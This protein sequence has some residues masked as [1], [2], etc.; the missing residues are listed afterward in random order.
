ML[1]LA[2][3]QSEPS[4]ERNRSASR[5]LVGEDRRGE[6]LLDARSGSRSPR[7]ASRRSSRRGS[8]RTSPRRRSASPGRA[9]TIVGSTKN[10]GRSSRLPPWTIVAPLLPSPRRAPRIIAVDGP[11][12]D[13]RAHQ[14]PSSQGSPILIAL[15]GADQPV[16]ERVGDRLVDD[17]PPERRAALAGGPDGGEQRRRGG[18]G[19]GRRSGRRSRALLPPSSRSDR[20]SRPPTTSADRRAPSGNCPSP[21]S[22]GSRRSAAIR[23]ARS[24]RRR[25]RG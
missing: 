15:V 13:Q 6:P 25:R 24:R 22:A 11:L 10:P 19:R 4:G 16:E 14:T 20:P 7:R 5:Q 18:P 12:V 8:A 21:R 23:L 9:R 2:M 1:T 17:Q 3:P